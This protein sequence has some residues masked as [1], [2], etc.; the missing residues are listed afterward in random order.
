VWADQFEIDGFPGV[1]EVVAGA[2]GIPASEVEMV[3]P[4][5]DG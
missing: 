1:S 2:L 3:A 4:G 5:E